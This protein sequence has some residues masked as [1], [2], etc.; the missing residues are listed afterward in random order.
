MTYAAAGT[1]ASANSSGLTTQAHT[2]AAIGNCLVLA[3]MLSSVTITVSS[4]SGGGATGWQR[5]AAPNNDGGRTQEMWMGTVTATGAQTITVTF[6]ASTA[7]LATDLKV[8]EFSSSL[9]TL[10]KWTAD[11]SGWRTNAASFTQI[12]PALAPGLVSPELYIGQA[13]IAVA[14]AH[15]GM[16]AGFT[17]QIDTNANPYIYGSVTGPVT[18]QVTTANSVVSALQA[19]LISDTRGPARLLAARG[20]VRVALTAST[21]RAVYT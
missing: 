17:E 3:V 6:S 13:R 7:G 20:P 18:P 8:Q 19:A 14:G 16:T 15:S 5:I 11:T 1:L 12:Y 10:A 21:P 2:N 9:G 4:V